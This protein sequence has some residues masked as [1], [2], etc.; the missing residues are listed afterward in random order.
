MDLNVCRA[1]LKPS[2]GIN[3]FSDETYEKFIF[4]TSIQV[5]SN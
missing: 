2:V 3:L 1:C 4:T 5:S